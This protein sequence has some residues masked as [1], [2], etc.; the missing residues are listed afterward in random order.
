[1][2]AYGEG[3]DRLGRGD[4]LGAV[5]ALERAVAADG[6]F[7]PAWLRLADAYQALGRDE[8]ATRAVERAA[9]SLGESADRLATEVRARQAMLRGDAP[10]ADRLLGTLATRYPNDVE[11]LVLRGTARGEGGHLESARRALEQAVGRDP[12]HPRA[13][14]LLAKYAIQAGDARRAVDDYLVR[15]MVIQNQLD[16]DQGRADVLN[17]LG[18]AYEHLGQLEQAEEHYRRAATLRERIGDTRGFATTLRNLASLAAIAGDPQTATTQLEHARRLLAEVGDRRGL[19]EVHNDRGVLAEE[20]GEY[21]VALEEYRSA[22]QMRQELG[23]QR[24]LAESHNNVGFVYYVLGEHDNAMIYWRQALALH[25]R[26]GNR[27]GALR[28]QQSIAMLEL[29]LGR[30]EQATRALLASLEESRRLG[31]PDATAVAQGNLGR[32]AHLQGRY[33]AALDAYQQAARIVAELDDLRGKVEFALLA[34]ETRLEVGDLAGAAELLAAAERELATGGSREHLARLALLRGRQ[35]LRAGRAGDARQAF[36]RAAG[37]AAAGQIAA[38][39][40]EARL[41]DGLAALLAGDAAAAALDEVTAAADRLGDVP[42]RLAARDALARAELAAGR[43]GRAADIARDGLAALP[44]GPAWGG[45]W[46]L[47]ATLAAAAGR[48]G[49]EDAARQARLRAVAEV[50]RLRRQLPAPLRQ[51]FDELPE[52]RTLAATPAH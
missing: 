16:N 12:K 43:P 37:E 19:A 29:A 38:L 34:A 30:W 28:A 10:T 13:W 40:L 2:G 20:Q 5:A 21:R 47:H 15:A 27:H 3:R 25:E 42:L 18:V 1:M 31:L 36:T 11:L 50:E 35:A 41:G 17:A 44:A 49:D 8:D 22:L 51:R 7:T 48:L 9:A 14:Y 46:R 26:E 23:D 33:P 32:L 45:A 4:A 39:A 52:V 6:T 24:G